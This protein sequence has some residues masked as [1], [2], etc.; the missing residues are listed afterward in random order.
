MMLIHRGL[1][2]LPSAIAFSSY[3]RIN[4]LLSLFELSLVGALR[5]L[6]ARALFQ[7]AIGS[8]RAL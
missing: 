1:G 2:D 5:G 3:L 6:L 7:A 4:T 8:E